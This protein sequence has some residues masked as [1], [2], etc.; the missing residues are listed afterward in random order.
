MLIEMMFCAF[1]SLCFPVKV[2]IFNVKAHCQA[3]GILLWVNSC[4][5]AVVCARVT[6]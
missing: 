6:R 2:A 5:G 1:V 3:D 4:S